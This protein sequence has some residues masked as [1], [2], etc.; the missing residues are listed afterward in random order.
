MSDPR[1]LKLEEYIQGAE[2]LRQ[3]VAGMTREQ[4]LAKPIPGKWS[5]LEVVCH[6]ADFEPIYADRIK[7]ILAEENPKMMSG[8]PDLFAA[9]LA[10]EHRD[11]DVELDIITSVR[12]Q[13]ARILEVQSAEAFQR[14]GIHS[15]DGPVT[16]ETL[17]KRVTNH[18]THH[19]PF[20]QE[21]RKALGVS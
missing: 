2:Q 5:T 21:K 17:L 7:R 3:A 6:I 13:L 1:T 14:T 18:I 20:I 4:L 10:Y 19:L 15:V 16:I 12:K 11:L 9:K 8:D